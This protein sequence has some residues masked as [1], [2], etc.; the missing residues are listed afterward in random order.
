MQALQN[1]QAISLDLDDTLWPV[2]PAIARAEAVLL[3]WLKVHAPA[4]A[5]MLGT[6]EAVR[7]I[8]MQVERENPAMKHDLSGLRRESIRLALRNAGENPDL[9]EPAF[10]LFFAERQKVNLFED[11]LPLLEFLSA[12]WPVVALSNGNADV[13][14]IGL[15]KYFRASLNV[16]ST[17][18]AKPDPRM[19]AAAA[20]TLRVRPEQVLHIGDDAALDVEGALAAGMQAAWLNRKQAPWP[21][22][23]AGR[24]PHRHTVESLDALRDLLVAAG[25]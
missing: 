8:R 14:L 12:R 3:D 5:G 1:I 7:A 6:T 25:H 4:T 18:F 24:N 9:A 21:H 22:G 2:W 15:G 10:T 11:A 16:R 17:G 20:D 23:E 13:D 19:F